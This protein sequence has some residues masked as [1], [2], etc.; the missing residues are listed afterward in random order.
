MDFAVNTRTGRLS[1]LKCA[2]TYSAKFWNDLIK[3]NETRGVR[4]DVS[5]N[6]RS[7]IEDHR[8]RTRITR[9]QGYAN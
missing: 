6:D 1:E 9:A 2:S 5:E 8:E 3:S 7:F 4:F